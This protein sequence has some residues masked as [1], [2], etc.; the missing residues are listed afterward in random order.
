MND[1]KLVDAIDNLSSEVKSLKWMLLALFVV[2][3]LQ[4]LA[5]S[6]SMT[7]NADNIARAIH[8]VASEVDRNAR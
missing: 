7:R 3:I 5:L 2:V 1:E 8:G 4:T 6:G